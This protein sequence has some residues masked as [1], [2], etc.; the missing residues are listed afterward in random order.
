MNGKYLGVSKMDKHYNV[1]KIEFSGE[2]IIL[3]VDGEVYQIQID[4]ASRRLAQATD[5]ERKMY[6]VSPSGYGIHWYAINEDLTT[7]RL[8][9]LAE[10]AKT[11]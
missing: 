6:R 10:I 5:I 11:A 9:N 7:K 3:S 1:S 2:W 8:I 4:Q